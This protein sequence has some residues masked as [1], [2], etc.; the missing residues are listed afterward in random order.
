[1]EDEQYLALR[2]AIREA[3][4]GFSDLRL[5]T[6]EDMPVGDGTLLIERFS[7]RIEDIL[8]WLEEM[9]ESLGQCISQRSRGQEKEDLRKALVLCESLTIKVGSSFG[10]ELVSF[11][12]IRELRRL[13]RRR[14]PE[15]VAWV[16]SI[17]HGLE[18]CRPPLE[19]LQRSIVLAWSEMAKQSAAGVVVTNTCVGVTHTPAGV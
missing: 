1:M 17:E 6:V 5:T 10:Q 14:G 19:R 9:A 12:T 18:A 2:S 4:T 15:W 8:G 7:D 3:Y 16:L 11:E 13:G